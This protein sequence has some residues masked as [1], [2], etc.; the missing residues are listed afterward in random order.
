MVFDFGYVV[1]EVECVVSDFYGY[2]FWV[3]NN[4]LLSVKE[5]KL[6]MIIKI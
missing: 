3:I 6:L 2:I 1:S 4:W 5:Y